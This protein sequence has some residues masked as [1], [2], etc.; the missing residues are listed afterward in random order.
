MKTTRTFV[1]VVGAA[2]GLSALTFPM[3]AHAAGPTEDPAKAAQAYF[4][5][6]MALMKQGKYAEACPKLEQSQTLD[7]GMGTKYRLAECYESAGLVGRAWS[8]FSEVAVEAKAA[9]RADR[10]E[11]A[12]TRAEALKAKVPF[13]V[14]SVS[15]ETAS[16][17]GLRVERDGEIVDP[18]TFGVAAPVDPGTHT[19]RVSA[20]GKKPWSE[21][22]QSLGGATLDV[23]LP[24]LAAEEAMAAPG[25][26]SDGEAK[27]AP[28]Q[29][30]RVGGFV[31]AG[32]GVVM[33]GVGAGFGVRASSLWD[34]A[35]SHCRGGD[36]NACDGQG[37]SL[38][39]DASSAGTISTVGFAIGGVGLASGL[40]MILLAPKKSPTSAS[41]P[42]FLVAPLLGREQVGTVVQGR[43]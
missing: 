41:K 34:D 15:K 32:V 35:L 43:F 9:K 21:S 37:I 23:K 30:M 24:M 28:L 7:P 20:D 33:L 19:I 4:D 11:Q 26:P 22:V 39:K 3:R 42:G 16:L 10:E 38:G 8:L 31:A 1:W 18:K 5:E 2:I 17:A 27:Q 25:A 36:K 40:V 12:R 29:G 6:A 13:L 14:I